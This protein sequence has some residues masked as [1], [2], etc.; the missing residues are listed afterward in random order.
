MCGDEL[1]LDARRGIFLQSIHTERNLF[2]TRRQTINHIGC[3]AVAILGRAEPRRP[4]RAGGVAAV[5][6][7]LQFAIE[8]RN[9]A[10]LRRLKVEGSGKWVEC[11]RLTKLDRA[12]NEMIDDPQA[13]HLFLSHAWPAAQDRMRIVKARFLECLPTCRTFLDVDDLKSGSGTAEVDKSECILVFCTSQ[14]TPPW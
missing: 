5:I 12:T 7:L 4:A 2:D 6:V 14:V 13:F 8:S 1:P 10:K 9:L 11:K 3:R